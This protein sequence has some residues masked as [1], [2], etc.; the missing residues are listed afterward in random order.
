[1]RWAGMMA[2]MAGEETMGTMVVGMMVGEGGISREMKNKIE[3]EG[4]E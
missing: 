2:G 4:C 1:M 3:L